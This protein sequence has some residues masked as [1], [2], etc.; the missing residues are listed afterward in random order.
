MGFLFEDVKRINGEFVKEYFFAHP[1]SNYVNSCG[2]SMVSICDK[3]ASPDTKD[4]F[5]LLVGFREPLPGNIPF[6]TEYQGVRVFT[7][8]IGEIRPL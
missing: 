1:Y 5:C 7:K 2:I 4:D 3:E 6:P 8:V